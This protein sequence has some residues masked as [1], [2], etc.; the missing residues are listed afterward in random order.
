[1]LSQGKRT[2]FPAISNSSVHR[3]ASGEAHKPRL[4]METSKG[5]IWSTSLSEPSSM[6]PL[7][8]DGACVLRAV[9]PPS[10]TLQVQGQ[11]QR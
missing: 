6:L 2:F 11:G 8:V 1:M 10:T 3:T 4:A 7:A 5:D 9:M